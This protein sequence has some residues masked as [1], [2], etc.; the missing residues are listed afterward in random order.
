MSFPPGTEMFQFPRYRPLKL[1]CSFKGTA[2]AVGFPI[3]KSTDQRLF[4]P[5][6]SISQRITSF[7]ASMGLGIHRMPFCA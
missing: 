7:I 5:P 2:H 1:F 3:R 4:A 6:R